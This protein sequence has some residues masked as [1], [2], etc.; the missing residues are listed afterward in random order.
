LTVR[1][2]LASL[3]VNAAGRCNLQACGTNRVNCDTHGVRA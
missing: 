1:T 3:Q 2:Y